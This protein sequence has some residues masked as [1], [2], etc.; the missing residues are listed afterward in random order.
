[1]NFRKIIKSPPLSYPRPTS[2]TKKYQSFITY[3]LRKYQPLVLILN[4][5]P[6]VTLGRLMFLFAVFYIVCIL[7]IMCIV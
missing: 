6:A 4:L 7:C 2:R 1:M 3:G 5:N